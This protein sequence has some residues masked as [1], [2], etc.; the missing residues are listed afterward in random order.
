M[1]RKPIWLFTSTA[2]PLP[3]SR[4]SEHARVVLRVVCEANLPLK[5]AHVA[6]AIA[7]EQHLRL[8]GEAL[9]CGIPPEGPFRS[10]ET[11]NK[12]IEGILRG[13]D[14]EWAVTPLA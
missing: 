12:L 10:D 13:E 11:L 8:E 1:I 7:D 3:S 2:L 6:R 4:Y 9:V 5:I 14:E